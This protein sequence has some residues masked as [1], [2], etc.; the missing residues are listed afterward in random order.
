MDTSIPP[1]Q[2]VLGK[3]LVVRD[4]DPTDP[5]KRKLIVVAVD[6]ASP[7]TIDVATLVASGAMITA[8][9]DGANPTSQTFSMPGPWTATGTSGAKYTDSAGVNGPVKVASLKK[10]GSGVLKLKVKVL[11]NLGPGP[12]PHILVVP[13]NPGTGAQAVFTVKG[14]G[15]YCVTFGDAA[16]GVVSNKAAKTFKMAK[17]TAEACPS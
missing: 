7:D 9:A 15:S 1:A 10:S 2:P 12:Q 13:P 3:S 11:G 14:G 17:P 4:P 6:S 5:S 16:G 8:S